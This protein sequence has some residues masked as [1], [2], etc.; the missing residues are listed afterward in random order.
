MNPFR[1]TISCQNPFIFLHFKLLPLSYE[2]GSYY[3]IVFLDF[4]DIFWVA[5]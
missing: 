3:I 5:Y 2:R 1:P 4:G